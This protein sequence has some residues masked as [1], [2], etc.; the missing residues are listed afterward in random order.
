MTARV[1]LSS[2]TDSELLVPLSAV[3]DV[4]QGPF[5]RI[6]KD[7]KVA[8]RPVKIAKFREDGAAVSGGLDSGD[9]VIVSGAAKLVDGQTVQVRATT[10]PDRQ[11]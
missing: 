2:G 7:D 10:P 4:G 6:V 5:V 8:S 9:T 11:R 1:Y 3:L